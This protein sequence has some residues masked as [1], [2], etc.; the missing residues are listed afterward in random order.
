MGVQ[1]RVYSRLHWDK[2][3][4]DARIDIEVKNGTAILRGAVKTLQAKTRALE[5]ARDTIGVARV[6]DHLTIDAVSPADASER[7]EKTKP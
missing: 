3:L 2:N 1:T 5:L 4:G 7:S 6:D